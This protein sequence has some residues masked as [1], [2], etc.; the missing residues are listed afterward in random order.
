VGFF[1]LLLRDKLVRRLAIVCVV[2]VGL[3]S[4]I[5]LG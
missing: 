4:W 1:R 3:G 5:A 2:A